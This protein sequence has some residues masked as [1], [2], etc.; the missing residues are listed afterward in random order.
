VNNNPLDI[1]KGLI[2]FI[3]A[4][5]TPY[6]AVKSLVSE[7]EEAGFICLEESSEW[8][9]EPG[10]GYFVSRSAS[11]IIA[12]KTGNGDLPVDGFRMVGAHTDSPC[13]KIKPEPEINQYQYGQL[14][15]EVYGGVLLNPWFDRDLSIAGRVDY[16]DTKSNLCHCLI[17]FEKAVA[18]IP[19]LAIHLDRDANDKRAINAQTYLP[20]LLTQT[21]DGATFKLKDMLLDYLVKELD[22]ENAEKVLAYDL[23][24]YDVQPPALVGLNDEFLTGARLDNLLSCYVGVQSLIASNDEY[25][26]L[27]VC[28]DH[29]EVGSVSAAGAKG[30]FL[31]AV[32]ERVAESFSHANAEAKRRMLDKSLMFS[33]DNAHGIHPNFPEKHDDKHGPLLNHGPVI[34]INANQRYATSSET[35]AFFRQLC[36]DNNVPVQAFVVRNDMACGSTIGPIVAGELGVKTLDIGVPTFAMHSIREM[37]GSK[38]AAYLATALTAFYNR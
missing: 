8:K 32:L 36:E 20:P 3:Q 21:D 11:S 26:S 1:N 25:G 30:P 24:L 18:V 28:S 5:P 19:S 6:H 4:S 13:L 34:K 9:L 37:A 33:V 7:L 12:F 2:N 31:E 15:V 27:L 10:Q 38:D 22:L 14:G 35:S 17:N 23:R 29:E 16:R